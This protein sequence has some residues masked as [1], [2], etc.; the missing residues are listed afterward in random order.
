MS[1]KKIRVLIAKRGLDG[2]DRGAKV[3]A[4]ANALLAKAAAPDMPSELTESKAGSILT[5]VVT[6]ASALLQGTAML[7]LSQE[8]R[9]MEGGLTLRDGKVEINCAF[10]TQLRMLRETMAAEVAKTLFD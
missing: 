9:E 3:V 8:T 6:G 5:K 10:E 2:H 7:T 1:E 4:R